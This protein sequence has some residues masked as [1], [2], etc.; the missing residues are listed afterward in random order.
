MAQKLNGK[1][2]GYSLAILSGLWM[3]ILGILGLLGYAAESIAWMQTH[4]LFFNVSFTGILTG[5][6]E[7]S[8]Y[9]FV[10]GWLLAYLY[11]KFA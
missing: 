1:A 10:I 5:I 8:V 3:L 4:H 11:N 7:A 2:L 9:G 6:I